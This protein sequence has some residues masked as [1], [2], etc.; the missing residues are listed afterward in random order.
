M[1]FQKHNETY[2]ITPVQINEDNP[3]TLFSET[4]VRPGH[5]PMVHITVVDGNGKSN[6]PGSF[7]FLTISPPSRRF[8]NSASPIE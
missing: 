6:G 1:K 5:L 4:V 3:G 7:Y 8:C 2:R